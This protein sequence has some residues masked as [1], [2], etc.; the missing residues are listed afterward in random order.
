MLGCKLVGGVGSSLPCAQTMHQEWPHTLA[1]LD[2]SPTIQVVTGQVLM[3]TWRATHHETRATP[4]VPITCTIGIG[5][6]D[7]ATITKVE[8]VA[9]GI[10]VKLVGVKKAML[11]GIE[12]SDVAGD[13]KADASDVVEA[14][15][16]D[17]VGIEG[18]GVVD[19]GKVS[20]AVVGEPSVTVVGKPVAVV[21]EPS[22]A[23]V[24]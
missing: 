24:R 17:G 23:V 12:R 8:E 18:I 13:R 20:V 1:S 14:E 22:V 11:V 6:S 9:V 15:K 7:A 16:L 2:A 19:V 3:S 4:R 5:N 10:E 21:G